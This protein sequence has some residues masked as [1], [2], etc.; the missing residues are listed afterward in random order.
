MKKSAHHANKPWS[1][2]AAKVAAV[3]PAKANDP[4]KVAA[5]ARAGK[6]DGLTSAA[7]A[8]AKVVRAAKADAR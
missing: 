4:V 2:S 6:V 1:F 5:L 3:A 8:Q 7:D